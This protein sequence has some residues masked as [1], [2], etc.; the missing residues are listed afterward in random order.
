MNNKL[1]KAG[2]AVVI[3]ISA[4]LCSCAKSSSH[5]NDK[6]TGLLSESSI[7][8]QNVEKEII[9][10]EPSDFKWREITL[11]EFPDDAGCI[12]ITG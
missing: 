1:L 8:E 4:I 2:F 7:S 6:E 10:N 12:M 9:P 5:T 3:A 11:E